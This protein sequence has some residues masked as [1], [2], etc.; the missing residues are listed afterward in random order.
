MPLG[1]RIEDDMPA[2]EARASGHQ[3]VLPSTA[4]LI[5]N[6]DMPAFVESRCLDVLA[7]N[8]LATAFSP[9]LA[10]GRNRLKDVFLDQAEAAMFPGRMP[11][12]NA[13]TRQSDSPATS[14]SG[15]RTADAHQIWFSPPSTYTLAPIM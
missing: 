15:P 4:R 9:R 3:N 8:P 12:S 10:P 5:Q 14:S 7:A 13:T 1:E 11:P 6:L 2:D